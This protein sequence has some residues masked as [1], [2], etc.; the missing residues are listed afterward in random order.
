MIIL[1]FGQPASGKTTLGD[2]L[3]KQITDINDKV[4]RIDGDRW[5][6]VTRNKDY[7]REGRLRNLKGAFD[8]AIYLE[9]EGH[10]PILS[11]VT[12]Y[13][14]LRDHLLNNARELFQ[15]H[16]VYS[17]GRGRDDKFAPDFERPERS[18]LTVDTSEMDIDQSLEA[19][20]EYLKDYFLNH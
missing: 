3:A 10:I 6:D 4:V 11:F 2:A 8:M 13:Q 18:T 1:L 20:W 7:S 17:G 5:R 14:E 19:I 16:L 12:P 9:G 15:V